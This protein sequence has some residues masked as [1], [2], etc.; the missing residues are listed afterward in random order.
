M[1]ERSADI[2]EERQERWR[3]GAGKIAEESGDMAGRGRKNKTNRGRMKDRRWRGVKLQ[4]ARVR[5]IDGEG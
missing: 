4:V 3:R 5:A 1:K 2:E